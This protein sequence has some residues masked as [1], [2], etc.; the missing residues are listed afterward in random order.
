MD[1]ASLQLLTQCVRLK[2]AAVRQWADTPDGCPAVQP[3]T[4]LSRLLLSN[5]RIQAKAAGNARGTSPSDDNDFSM[6]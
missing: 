5:Q 2:A 4:T 6:K 1:A 3:G